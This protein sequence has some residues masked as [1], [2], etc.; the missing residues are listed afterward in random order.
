MVR[1]DYL[2]KRISEAPRLDFGIIFSDSIELF[3]K[4]WVYGFLY[5]V[6]ILIISLGIS[7]CTNPT[8]LVMI[9]NLENPE[10]WSD[11]SVFD[12]SSGGLYLLMTFVGSFVTASLSI[13]L[14]SGFLRIVRNIDHSQEPDASDLF[15]YFKS[16][17]IF[18]AMALAVA[19]FGIAILALILCVFPIIYVAVGL[20]L[21]TFVFAFNPDL[22]LG[23]I[24]KVA[25]TL[26]HNKWG[27]TMGLLIV[28]GL[29]S[30]IIGLLMC[31]VGI[32]LTASFTVLPSYFVYKSVIGFDQIENSE[33]Q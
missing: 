1:L 14:L 15:F 16:D 13:L 32:F 26:G 11:P 2:L 30:T 18:K 10:I 19:T 8:Y 17:Y 24:I 25:F 21:C 6:I 28:A 22:T 33:V 23:E 20:T 7:F 5:S 12:G 3:K 31:I 9:R 4:T 27:I 29:L